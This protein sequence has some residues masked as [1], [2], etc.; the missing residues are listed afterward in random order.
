MFLVTL[1]VL[2]TT[3]ALATTA[4]ASIARSYTTNRDPLDVAIGDFNCD[5]FNDMAV[6]T[7]GTHTISVLWNDGNGDFSE[8]Q[9]IWVSQNQSRNA[10]WDEFSNVQFIEV[11]EFTGD[12]A[13]DIVIFQR[14]NPFKTDDNGAPAGEP[15]NVTIIENAGCDDDSWNIGQ[16]YTHFWAWDLA[17][18]DANQDG[19]DDIYILD[20]LSDVSTQRVVTYRGPIT[21]NTQGLVTSLG[22]SNQNAYRSLEVGD[23]GET[24]TGGLSGTCTDDDIWL[25][26]SE[27]VDYA[28]GQTT[29]PGNDDNVTIL[30]YSCLTNTY[31]ATFTYNQATPQTGTSLINMAVTFANDFDIGDI[32]NNGAIDSLVVNDG[33]VENVSYVTSSAVGTW[34]S[35]ASAYFGPYISYSVTVADLNNDGEPDF[36][37]PTVAYQQ[38]S[39][40]SA[41]GSTSNFFLNFPTTVQV[42]LSDGSGAHLTPLSYEAGRRPSMVE[43]GQLAGASNSALDIVV[44]HTS[45]DF[46]SWVDNFGWEGQ[47]DTITVVEMDSKDLAVTSLEI[48]PTDKFFG[49]V[50]EGTRDI[51]V[52]VT[53]TGMDI[54]NGQ[55]ATLDLELKIVDEAGST[56]STVYEMDWDAPEDKSGCGSGCDWVFEEYIDQATKWHEETNSSQGASD[57]NN[58]PNVSANYQNPTDFMWA[59]HYKINFTGVLW[60]GYDKNWDDVM[61]FENVD[62]IGSDRAFMS[63]ELF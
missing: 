19:E 15:G 63:V 24:E 58:D 27:G 14:N 43:V 59:G 47:Y 23:W 18:G 21:S 38:N 57:G 4:S 46:G 56:N 16:R 37:N 29:N 41:G 34:T 2:S 9:D 61:V 55:S 3:A 10:D 1:M 62:L 54:L 17:V 39:S 44:G 26:R 42:T 31:P 40:D 22:P 52:T 6:A 53:N 60:F 33:N 48:S 5:G 28:T 50:G 13:D 11:G 7:E 51:N 49:I 35:P 25:L 8:R 12:G 32:D 36:V 20:L 30:E 45:Y